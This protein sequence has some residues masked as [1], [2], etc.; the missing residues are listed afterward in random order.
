MFINKGE[1]LLNNKGILIAIF[2]LILFLL[3][4]YNKCYINNNNCY[5][6]KKK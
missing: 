4:N 2:I 6:L 1:S 5:Q 3:I